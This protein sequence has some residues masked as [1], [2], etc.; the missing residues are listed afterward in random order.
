MIKRIAA[1]LALCFAALPAMA[2]SFGGYPPAN[3]VYVG[4]GSSSVPAW[5]QTLPI[6]AFPNGVSVANPGTGTPEMLLPIQAA[7][8]AS[9]TFATSDLFKKTRRSNSGSAMTDTFPASSATGMANGTRI[10]LA[11]A[12]ASASDT[13]TAGAGTTFSAC[14]VSAGSSVVVTAGRDVTFVYD[15]PNTTWRADANTCTGLINSNNLSDVSSA[16]T[17]RTNLGL[18]TAAVDN[19]G[20]SGATIPLLNG[21]NVHSGSNTF[22]ALTFNGNWTFSSTP[23]VS[24]LSSVTC[25]NTLALSSG[26]NLGIASCPGAASSIQ[27][28]SGGT[29]ITSGTNGGLLWDN[30]G[31][32]YASAAITGLIL[33]NGTS[34]PS[35]ATVSTGLNLSAGTLTNTGV[36]NV[37]HQAF[38]TTG[39]NTYT[40]HAGLIQADVACQAGGGGGGGSVVSNS[41][42]INAGG[43]GGQGGYAQGLFS[44]ATIGASQTVTIGTGGPGGNGA[45][46]TT[47]GNTTFGTLLTTNGGVGG[48]VGVNSTTNTISGGASGGGASGGYKDV[49]GQTGGDGSGSIVSGVGL[50]QGGTG[51]G[52]QGGTVAMTP[53]GSINGVS[54]TGYGNGGGG[55]SAGP[56]AGSTN[57]GGSGSQGRCDVTEYASQ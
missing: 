8:G 27:A 18:G 10:Q 26:G 38:T 54:A 35:A 41:S 9:K 40:P 3:Y 33:G 36:V 48:P 56:S 21:N 34:A 37:Y 55:A 47:G 53:S 46:G 19:T 14:G 5:L 28:G 42:Q 57:V 32:L 43:G 25:A 49:T 22:A 51:G 45:N 30:S 1:A 50:A 29:S 17:A 16:S 12:D 11:N 13:I 31:T 15:L 24:G 20:T 52:P 6:A 23:A 7:T 44:A 2:Q 39:S 4:Q